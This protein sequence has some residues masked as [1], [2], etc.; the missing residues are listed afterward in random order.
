[1]LPTITHPVLHAFHA[2]VF[3]VY[4]GCN[5]NG[6]LGL[7]SGDIEDWQISASSTYPS[8]W[9]AGCHQR[10]ARVYQ[11]NGVAW[12]AKHKSA[13]EWLQVDLGIPAKV[14]LWL[15]INADIYFHFYFN[16]R[17]RLWTGFVIFHGK[18]WCVILLDN[19]TV[20]HDSTAAVAKLN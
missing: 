18:N 1:M 6:P 4:A 20:C 14:G 5:S 7:I 19:V 16:W 17:L 8:T 2:L 10:Y 13:S 11:P 3:C 15:R 12:C 9:D